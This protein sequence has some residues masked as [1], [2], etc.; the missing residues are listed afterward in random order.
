MSFDL[1]K[2]LKSFRTNKDGSVPY[3]VNSLYEDLAYHECD[4]HFNT[5]PIS[6]EIFNQFNN[7]YAS[8]KYYGKQ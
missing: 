1:I 6:L 4:Y 3:T 2:L 8:I 5:P 7:Q